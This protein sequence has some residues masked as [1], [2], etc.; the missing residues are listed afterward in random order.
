MTNCILPLNE[1]RQLVKDFIA[2][3]LNGDVDG[4]VNYDLTQLRDTIRYGDT[5]GYAFSIYQTDLVRAIA[6]IVFDDIASKEVMFGKKRGTLV[7]KPSPVIQEKV[8][9][10]QVGDWFFMLSRI[11]CGDKAPWVERIKPCAD[12]CKTIG[13][14]YL[15]PACLSDYRNRNV[16]GR[17]LI[18]HMLVDLQNALVA[19]K[20][21]KAIM[22]A[23]SDSKKFFEPYCGAEGWKLLMKRWLFD[24]VLMDYY[25]NPEPFTDDFSLSDHTPP[26]VYFK[27]LEQQINLCHELIPNRSKR[28]VERLKERL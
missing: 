8:W 9:G 4:L 3:H 20:G 25:G 12:L 10:T 11:P 15:Q 14:I 24:E 6:T 22:S 5:R 23:I 2:E 26:H 7:L 1:P 19:G 17:F 28:M 13:N 21:S 27:A 16:F 18:D